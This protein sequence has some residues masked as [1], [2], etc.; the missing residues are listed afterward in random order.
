MQQRFAVRPG[1]ETM[2]LRREI[3]LQ[4][5]VVVDLA[6]GNQPE[7]TVLVGERLMSAREID[8][9]QPPH[10]KRYRTVGVST[11]IVRAAMDG[12]LAHAAQHRGGRGLTVELE[13]SID[14]AHDASLL[15][16]SDGCRWPWVLRK[17]L[18]TR[19]RN[20][21]HCAPTCARSRR[22][23]GPV[24]ARA[25]TLRPGWGRPRSPE[26][27]LGHRPPQTGSPS[28]RCGPVRDGRRRPMPR[29]S[30]PAPSLSAV[31]AG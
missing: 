2:P 29:I 8:N 15:R 26:P 18:H 19:R 13:D 10:P 28:H 22:S 20:G 11:L 21:R 23:A 5:A 6:V 9:G 3:A 31:F 27:T 17:A 16:A 7:G 30:F 14:P 24:R 12:P 4:L 1:L 25:A